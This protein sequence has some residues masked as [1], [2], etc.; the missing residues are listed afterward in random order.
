MIANNF[1]SSKDTEER[2]KHSMSGNTEIK[3]GDE[4]NEVIG[5]LFE[6]LL[7]RYQIGLRESMIKGTDFV[8]VD[9]LYYKCRNINPNRFSRLDKKS[10][11]KSKNVIIN[12]FNMLQ[13]LHYIIKKLEKK[14]RIFNT[15]PFICKYNWKGINY[16]SGKDNNPTIALNVLYTKNK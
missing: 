2:V 14:I 11:N 13:Q 16:P 15:E 9:S 8:F 6:S 5:K 4:A 3:I 10:N 12:A 1:M 7:S